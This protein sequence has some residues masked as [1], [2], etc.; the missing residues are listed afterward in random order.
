MS[1]N[2][3]DDQD[4]PPPAEEENTQPREPASD[5]ERRAPLPSTTTVPRIKN[6]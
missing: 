4:A 5:F 6:N 3:N 1:M 2:G